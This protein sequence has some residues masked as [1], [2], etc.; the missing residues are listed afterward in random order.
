[1]ITDEY[2]RLCRY[3]TNDKYWSIAEDVPFNLK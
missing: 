1:V 2:G 3:K